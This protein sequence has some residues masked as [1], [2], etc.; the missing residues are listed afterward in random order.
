MQLLLATNEMTDQPD[1][2]S[3]FAYIYDQNGDGVT[4]TQEAALRAI[5][6]EIYTLIN[7]QGDV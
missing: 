5:A 4:D 1:G 2:I 6:N 3:G 7:K